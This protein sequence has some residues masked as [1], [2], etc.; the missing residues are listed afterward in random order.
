MNLCQ[1]CS[2]LRVSI[3]NSLMLVL[4]G[5]ASLS[6][7]AQ[8]DVNLTGIVFSKLTG[9]NVQI[10][11]VADGPLEKPGSFSTDTPA[12]IALDFFGM[13]SQLDSSQT[14]VESGKVRSVV[15]VETS[16]RTR[17]I[18]N[19]Y[20]SSRYSIEEIEN[21]YSVTVFKDEA[22]LTVV[23]APKPFAKRPD[24]TPDTVVSNIDFR[25]S[26]AGGGTLIVDMDGEGFAVDTR[27]HDGEIIVDLLGVT[28]PSDLEQ[29]LDVRDFATPVQKIDSFQS[30][31]N[32]RLVIVPQ[33]K[34]QHLSFQAGGRFTL[35][36]DPIIE[37]EEDLRNQE[38]IDLGYEG[39]RLSINFQ[40][41]DVRSALAVIADFTGI[42]FVT[43]DSVQGNIALNLKDVPWDQALDVILRTKGL[44]QRT[45][46]NVTWI[47]PSDEIQR[48]EEE[49]LKASAVVAE[50]APLVT[51]VIQINYARASDVSDVVKSVRVVSQG[52]VGSNASVPDGLA[53]ALSATETDRNSI[54]SPRGSVTVD[55]RT[56]SLLV[57][58]VPE[59]IRALRRVIAKLDKPVR[60]VLIETRIVQAN[61][62]F[63]RELG[64]RLGFQRVTENAQFPGSNSSDIGT[65]IGSGTI[66]GVNTLS[67][68]FSDQQTE[69]AEAA[70]EGDTIVP[71]PLTFDTGPAGLAV[72][73]GANAIGGSQAAS[74][75]VD[76]LKAGAGFTNL[77]T[78]ELSALE[79][80]G[81]G[82]IVAS[83]R[84]VTANQREARISQGQEVFVTVPGNG[85]GVGVGGGAAGT[86]GG[87]GVESI[88]ALLELVVTPQITPDDRI[89][90]D[91]FITQDQ[92]VASSAAITTL[93]TQEIETQILA[94]NGET[95]VIGGIYQ[96][97]NSQGETKVPLLG[98]VP[99][100]GNFFKRKSKQSNRTELLIF[101]TP[102]IISPKL[103]LG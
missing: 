41:I 102:K 87:G 48:Q 80:D 16:D 97:V 53:G 33:G 75:A 6:V 21:G 71:P 85:G 27:E 59:S 29:S 19:L 64:A 57:Q 63:S 32:A 12:R 83:P 36:V 103:N 11:I 49:E 28:L 86:G 10:N 31:D 56:N 40:N 62:N 1:T 92:L 82:K 52:N 45:T 3:R 26:D 90:L 95:V 77:I 22:D 23:S 5:L 8:Q 58:D 96:E 46:G 47:A 89:I 60:Q 35:I 25:R 38:D 9:D 43:S 73:L 17:V 68:S 37:T 39:E 101:L 76:I 61:D 15:A 66:G 51:E 42:N 99:F 70:L 14:I 69:L 30:S 67:N 91:V 18:V 78:L 74:Y 54:L 93:G 81:R 34:F 100:L 4:I 88:E 13:K 72:D 98:D 20:E 50:F 55:E 84:L 65:V 44:S 2:C 94:D 24:I 7:S 79:A